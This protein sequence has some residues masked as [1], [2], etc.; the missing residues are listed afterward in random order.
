[1]RFRINPIIICMSIVMQLYTPESLRK[2]NT[3]VKMIWSLGSVH[4]DVYLYLSSDS[5]D[6]HEQMAMSR[7]V[8]K[9]R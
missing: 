4:A 6:S 7:V 3:S 1:M 8:W 5:T 9:L 2:L